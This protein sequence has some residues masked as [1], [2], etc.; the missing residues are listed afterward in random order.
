MS[1]IVH[2]PSPPLDAYIKCL[3]HCEGP[4]AY[5]RLKVLPMPS[6]HLMVNFGDAYHV[7]EGDHPGPVATCAESWSVGLWK[8]YHVM[9]W[10]RDLRILNVSFRPGGAAPFLRLPLAELRN[11]VVS[12]DALWGRSAA[13]IRERL[14][15][16]PT[17]QARFALLE[18]LLLARLGEGPH[19]LDAGLET[20]RYAVAE[21]ARQRGA[22]SIG[23]LSQQIGISQKHLITQFT[24]LVGGTPKELARIY[25]FKHVLDSI[26][27]SIDPARPLNWAQ[28][29]QRSRYH[30]EAHFNKDFRAFTGQTPTDCLRLLR[31]IHAEHPERALYPKFLPIG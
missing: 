18:R 26:D 27:P 24:R 7:Y 19:G 28:I 13:E 22:L 16:A 6:L 12:L 5:P 15:T 30:D 31:R 29:A 2:I 8:T 1:T 11:Q 17:L 3:W 21:I 10:P 4:A 9:D 23:A 25:R 14:S 20:V